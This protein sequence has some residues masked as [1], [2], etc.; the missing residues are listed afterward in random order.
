MKNTR[1]AFLIA[2]WLACALAAAACAATP[3]PADAPRPRNLVFMIP[4]GCGPASIVLGRMC[5]G[6]PLA[7]DSI[8]VGAS[9]TSSTSSRVTDSAAGA[10]AYA[11]GIKT[12]NAMLGLDPEER[13]VGTLLEA[14]QARGMRTGMV[15]TC[16][17]THATPAA[18]ASHVPDRGAED[19]IAVQ[20]LE[21][22]VDLLLGG[23]RAN[24]LPAGAGGGR[25][26]GRD[27]LGEARR[28]GC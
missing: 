17:L 3:S 14:A 28:R 10:T 15:V 23:G 27:L 12:G 2:A 5:A 26:D 24:F 20:E 19:S 22:G 1:R 8:L 4:D 11:S 16:R 25:R 9:E 13:P 6:R 7:L 18:F 21:H